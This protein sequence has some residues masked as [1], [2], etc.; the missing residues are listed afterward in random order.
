M[1]GKSAALHGITHD[2]TPF[3]FSEDDPAADYMGDM[4]L[5]GQSTLLLLLLTSAD[6]DI[7]V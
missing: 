3:K 4:L 2:S 5:K 7:N 1:A 6:L